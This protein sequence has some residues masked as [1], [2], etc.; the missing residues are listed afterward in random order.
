MSA[1][2]FC[3]IGDKKIGPLDGQQ[4]K[5]V[6]AQGQLKP[7]HYVRR[8]S[9]GPWVPAGRI[10]GLFPEGSAGGSESAASTGKPRISPPK[11]KA[12]NLRTAAEAP[13]PPPAGLPHELMLGGHSQHG[14][15][16]VD[17]LDYDMTPVSVSRRKVRP[18][19]KGSKNDK[20]KKTN[21]V[22]ICVSGGCIAIFVCVVIGAAA[23]GLFSHK[24]EA[25]KDPFAEP[26]PQKSAQKAI[27]K[28]TG[29]KKQGKKPDLAADGDYR[30]AS[31]DETEVG[32]VV[33]KVLNPKRGPAPKGAKNV[34]GE[35]LIVPVN[36]NLKE[37][38]TKPVELTSWADAS[39]RNKVSL[40]DDREKTYKLLDQV[41]RS[42]DGKSIP[43]DKTRIQVELVFQAP[44]N[45]KVT[46]LKLK[47]PPAA[48]HGQGPMICYNIN[49]D[50][51]KPAADTTA[52]PDEGENGAAAASQ[53]GQK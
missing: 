49:A 1:D 7:E 15:L 17:G 39:L 53:S 29:D 5:K 6:V 24:E 28:G 37:A 10:K 9:E 14:Q 26:E 13:T 27:P 31:I 41:A 36:L 11:A 22:L 48:F 34:E 20:K 43:S 18:G 46:Q 45:P 38:S 40:A 19:M 23:N 44:T 4:L 3:K 35:V 42:G 32:N 51:I 21:V 52:K 50:D 30:Q 33:V 2:W 12:T 8:G 16:N 47:L 25:V